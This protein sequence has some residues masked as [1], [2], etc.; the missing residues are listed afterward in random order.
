MSS[1]LAGS[2]WSFH[3]APGAAVGGCSA[4]F[5][6]ADT[7]FIWPSIDPEVSYARVGRP[8]G[9][10]GAQWRLELCVM[11]VEALNMPFLSYVSPLSRHFKLVWQGLEKGGRHGKHQEQATWTIDLVVLRCLRFTCAVEIQV[12]CWA[13]VGVGGTRMPASR[14]RLASPSSCRPWSS[15]P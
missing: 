2:L 13:S 8:Q 7:D 1:S 12:R 10:W 6:V 3:S 15:S 5:L 14:A 4:S 9:C 11:V